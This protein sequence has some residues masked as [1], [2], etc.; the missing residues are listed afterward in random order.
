MVFPALIFTLLLVWYGGSGNP[1]SPEE[2]AKYLATAELRKSGEAIAT[3]AGAELECPRRIVS[4][5]VARARHPLLILAVIGFLLGR[6]G[7]GSCQKSG[8][9][10]ELRHFPRCFAR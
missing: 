6:V 1:I 4:H 3:A 2:V 8:A 9:P 10:R 5:I 7:A